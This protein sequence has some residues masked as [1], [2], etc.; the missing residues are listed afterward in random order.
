[1][2]IGATQI[3]LVVIGEHTLFGKAL[4]YLLSLDPNITAVDDLTRFDIEAVVA[5]K[6]DLIIVDLDGLSEEIEYKIMHLRRVLPAA[7]LVLLSSNAGIERMPRRLSLDADGL[8]LKDILPSELLRQLKLICAGERFVDPRL[9]T[10]R[11]PIGSGGRDTLDLSMRETDVIRLIA[12]GLSNKEISSR[13]SLS[14]KT[15]KNHISRIF[16][17]LHI[18]AR[19]QAAVHAIK[20]GLA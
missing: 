16:S 20:T 18:N 12:Q 2:A 15:V 1:M 4:S 8:L 11:V 9:R 14:E 7:R 13:L 5:M 19:S 17:K 3:R 6:A 10:V